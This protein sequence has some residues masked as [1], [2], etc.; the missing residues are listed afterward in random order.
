MA[1]FSSA[2]LW[3]LVLALLTLQFALPPP[4]PLP[5]AAAAATRLRQCQCFT[6]PQTAGYETLVRKIIR[7]TPKAALM[8]FAAF[9][10]CVPEA[11]AQ[12]HSPA[13][14]PRLS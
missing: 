9:M 3:R 14:L 13:T 11:A 2:T 4:L 12:C 5:A 7:K 1:P 8:S 6:S 10:W